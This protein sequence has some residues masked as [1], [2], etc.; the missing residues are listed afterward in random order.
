ME[1]IKD[2]FY[3]K[4]DVVFAALVV[5]VVVVVVF[6]SLGGWMF[7]DAQDNKYSEIQSKVVSAEDGA[8]SDGTESDA[9]QDKTDEANQ[10][11]DPKEDAEALDSDSSKAPSDS[12][13]DLPKPAPATNQPAPATNQPGAN[14]QPAPAQ[15]ESRSI[16]VAPG[17]TAQAIAESLKT[18]GLITDASAFV[19][20][21][22]SS[23][24]DTKLKAGDFLI[25]AGSTANQIIDILTK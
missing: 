4:S 22:S 24:K 19:H 6:N 9:G 21:L 3:D 23:G 13:K 10:G 5:C 7:V 25:P 18:S 15:G 1:K 2:F 14:S 17:S 11:L 16:I 8:K 12:S 20:A